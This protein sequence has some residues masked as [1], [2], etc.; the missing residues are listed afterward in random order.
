VP[1]WTPVASGN[2]D[3][4]GACSVNIPLSATDPIMYYALELP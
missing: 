2:F 3:G 4:T 1:N